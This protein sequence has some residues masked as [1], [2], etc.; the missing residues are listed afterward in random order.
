MWKAGI[1]GLDVICCPLLTETHM[2]K[3]KGKVTKVMGEF[4][5]G[6]LHSGSK[7]GPKV[8]SR[9]QAI[10]IGMSEARKA[11]KGYRKRA[12]KAEL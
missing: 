9:K 7:S 11:G 8:K 3:R 12:E 4:K 1:K 6:E 5:R 2:A 10:A